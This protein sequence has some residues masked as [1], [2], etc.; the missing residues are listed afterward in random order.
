MYLNNWILTIKGIVVVLYVFPGDGDNILTSGGLSGPI[1]I[2]A[3]TTSVNNNPEIKPDSAKM[4][5]SANAVLFITAPNNNT[6]NF[7]LIFVFACLC[8]PTS[9]ENELKYITY[10]Y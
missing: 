1:S 2:L 5:V 6:L 10:A 4:S 9:A 7:H 8:L 3:D